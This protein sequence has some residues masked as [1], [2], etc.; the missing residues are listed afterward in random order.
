M[1]KVKRYKKKILFTI[2]FIC[3]L[4]GAREFWNLIPDYS[5]SQHNLSDYSEN[6]RDICRVDQSG[7]SDLYYTY[8]NE[9]DALDDI[10]RKKLADIVE[11]LGSYEV[12]DV[13]DRDYLLAISASTG[14]GYSILAEIV[15]DLYQDKPDVFEEEYGYPLYY[16]QNGEIDINS[17]TLFTDIFLRMN[18]SKVK[19]ISHETDNSKYI[20][21]ML[22]VSVYGTDIRFDDMP[23][24]LAD[25]I[26][27]KTETV[28]LK[29]NIS[30]DTYKEYMSRKDYDYACIALHKFA[31]QPY[32][33]NPREYNYVSDGGHW[34]RITGITKDQHFIVSS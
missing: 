34:M 6:L 29:R 16:E 24:F 27:E 18:K 17:E 32:G 31:L 10:E 26:G 13:S 3:S 11:L 21:T 22:G 8:M 12:T 20:L 9:P 23:R 7:A 25:V 5:V 33:A 2:L 1:E 15:V 4:I 14:C 28:S 19:E 30:Y